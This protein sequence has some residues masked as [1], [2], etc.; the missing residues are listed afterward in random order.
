MESLNESEELV[1]AAAPTPRFEITSHDESLYLA[2]RRWAAESK[3]QLVWD[4]GKDF[5]ARK[6]IYNA[7]TFEQAVEQVMAD[8]ETSGYPLHACAY[9]N[10]VVR[11]LHISQNCQRK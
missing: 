10:N 7:Q 1:L 9:A 3:Y 4:A 2:L 8:T 11:V 5:P 6:T